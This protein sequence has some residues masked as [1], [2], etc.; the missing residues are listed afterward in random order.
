MSDILQYLDGELRGQRLEDFRAHMA[1]CADCRTFVEEEQALS[2]LLHQSRPLF[3]APK[4]LRERVQAIGMHATTE[5]SNPRSSQGG[6]FL[7]LREL[8]HAVSLP[9]FGWRQALAIVPVVVVCLVSVLIVLRQASARSYVDT[10]IAIHRSYVDGNLPLAIRSDS[11]DAVTAWLAGK[12]PFHF[13]LPDAQAKAQ[14]DSPYRLMG[15]SLVKYRNTSA[16]LVS[17]NMRAER[18]S[19]L[20]VSSGTAPA[21]GGEVVHSGGLSFHYHNRS[22][23]KVI[24]W[25]NEGVT[26][27]LVSSLPGSAQESCL[28][29]HQT[30]KDR[31]KFK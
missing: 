30:M 19:L 7:R 3:T 16:A 25:T 20:V 21:L 22:G 17:Y 12:L 31:D 18:I 2:L 5:A 1:E 9:A 11:P 28:V 10:A 24:T 14:G 8:M 26:Y 6:N 4:A 29:C 27:A 13:K 15:A 23:Y